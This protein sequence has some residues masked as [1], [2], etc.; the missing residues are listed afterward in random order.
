MSRISAC[1]G[2]SLCL[3]WADQSLLHGRCLSSQLLTPQA[4]HAS[5]AAACK[6]AGQLK[7]PTPCKVS[8]MQCY[9]E[10][11][12]GVLALINLCWHPAEM[13]NL[14]EL[15]PASAF[16][17]AQWMGVIANS[18]T[19]A[20]ADQ[21]TDQ[22]VLCRGREQEGSRRERAFSPAPDALPASLRPARTRHC[23]LS[24][25]PSCC[26]GCSRST[27]APHGHAW[28]EPLSGMVSHPKF[29]TPAPIFSQLP[30]PHTIAGNAC[31][32][33]ASLR[34]N[35]MGHSGRDLGHAVLAQPCQLFSL[36]ELCLMAW[37]AWS[38]V[39]CAC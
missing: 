18:V 36:A 20:G 13:P 28:G 32:I 2:H 39:F 11:N 30:S 8:A 25:R 10:R 27:P 3:Q 19:T 5:A 26:G 6:R 21:W 4:C 31:A 34:I 38:V 23:Q 12:T 35:G 9:H 22:Q 1:L 16:G 15:I 29:V 17:A 14:S 33:R 7:G 24:L 37:H